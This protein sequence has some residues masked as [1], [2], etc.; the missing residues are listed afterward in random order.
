MKRLFAIPLMIVL[1][2]GLVFS[3]CAAPA[4]APAPTAPAPGPEPPPIPGPAAPAPAPPEKPIEIIFQAEHPRPQPL[5]QN[6]ILPWVMAFEEKSGGRFKMF[7]YD[8]DAV[9]PKVG[10]MDGI[11]TNVLQMGVVVNVAEPGRY[12]SSDV[13]SLPFIAPSSTIASL[14]A[15][16]LYE[17]FPEWQ[18]EYPGGVK[19]LS[20]FVSASFQIHTVNKPI[21]AVEDL[22]GMKML[23]INAWALKVLEKVGAIPIYSHMWDVYEG[24][25]KG[26]AEGVLCP[27]APVKAMKVSEVAKYHTIINLCYDTFTIPISR[28]VFDGLPSDLQQLLVN[29]SGAKIS[30][31]NGYALDEGA[32]KDSQWMKGQGNTFYSLPEEEMAK[33]VELV[34]PIREDWVAE[35]EAKGLP[36][37]AV[38]DEALRYAKELEAQGKYIPEYP[39][40]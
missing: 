15:W 24:L 27:L 29:E 1:V 18:A 39:T 4:P 2:V 38:L 6:S 37:R 8:K 21:L 10:L 32:S 31:A 20:H 30:E 40:E 25:E 28:S 9:V 7:Y 3:G 36:G 14:V 23:G 26:M 5:T 17:T 11:A 13:M 16:H 12:P 35:M 34:M 33:F 19:V 22:R